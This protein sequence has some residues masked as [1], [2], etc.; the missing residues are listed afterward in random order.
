[1][2]DE[3]VMA[4]NKVRDMSPKR[5]QDYIEQFFAEHI[6]EFKGIEKE[7]MIILMNKLYLERTGEQLPNRLAFTAKGK[8]G[9]E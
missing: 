1:M 2:T 9:E 8:A 7:R 5:S 6:G 4:I 3:E